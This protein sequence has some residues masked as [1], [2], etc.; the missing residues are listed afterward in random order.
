M[1][2]VG[3]C[4]PYGDGDIL[5]RINTNASS[6]LAILNGIL[7]TTTTF[8]SS[9]YTASIKTPMDAALSGINQYALSQIIDINDTP[10]INKLLALQSCSGQSNCNGN[11]QADSWLPSNSL[12]NNTNA[13]T[14]SASKGNKGNSSTC[15]N[16]VSSASGGCSGC[17]DTS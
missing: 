12:I 6:N 14:C 3:A 17:M 2:Y 1:N 15:S 7:N 9:A 4:L 5:S 11:C 16:G 10:S 8:N 13:F